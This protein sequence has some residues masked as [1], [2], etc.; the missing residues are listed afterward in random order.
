MILTESLQ[1]AVKFFPAKSAIVCGNRRW[2]YGEFYERI[3]R[4]V[5]ALRGWGVGKTDKVAI[6][7]P[8]CHCFLEAYY[9]IAQVGAVSVPINYRLSPREIAFILQDS[10]SK[11]LIVDPE[12]QKLIDPVRNDI[13]ASK[14]IVWPGKE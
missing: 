6:L 1:K 7:H 11:I 12:F 5:H 9:A 8:N 10:E 2:S 13:G 4:V 3:N 14:K